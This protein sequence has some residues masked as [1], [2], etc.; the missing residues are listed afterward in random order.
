MVANGQGKVGF[1][2]PF[3][4]TGLSAIPAATNAYYPFMTDVNSAP[5][6]KPTANFVF[7]P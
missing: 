3:K 4:P 1:V 6:F 7:Y 5:V 2:T